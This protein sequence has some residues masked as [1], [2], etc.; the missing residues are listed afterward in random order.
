MAPKEYN[1]RVALF[2]MGGVGKT[3]IAIEYVVQFQSQYEGVYWIMA[4]SSAQLLSGF[5]SI[6]IETRCID[7]ASR[8]Q[9]EIAQCVLNWLYRTK[10]WLLVMDNL[11][12]ISIANGYLPRLKPGGGHVLITTRD[13]NSL[14]IP[15]EGM[16]IEVHEPHEA[17]ELILR[18]AQL[19]NEIGTRSAI[20]VEALEIVRSLGF[21]ALAIE[22]A[23]AYIREELARDIFM[24]RPIYLGQRRQLLDRQTAGNYYKNTVA[25]TWL[26]S[27]AVIEGRNPQANQL[28]RIFAFMNP[29]GISLEFLRPAYGI[30]SDI[31]QCEDLAIFNA[32]LAKA[33]RDL[34][35]FSLIFRRRPGLVQI[36]RLVQF[37]IKDR[38]STEELCKY[39][40]LICKLGLCVFPDFAPEMRMKCRQ[41]EGEIVTIISEIAETRTRDAASLMDRVGI[42]FLRDG[43]A[44]EAL[45]LFS[46]ATEIKKRVNGEE[47]PETVLSLDS[48]ASS[49]RLLGKVTEAAEMQEKVLE[50]KCRML[51]E[52]HP[53]TLLTMDNLANSYVSLG[54]VKEA[55]EMQE[56]V[57]EVK[58]RV[59][60]EEHP[61]TLSTM[62]NLANSYWLLGKAEEIAGMQ[63]EVLEAKCRVLGE[64]H[65]DTLL[66][67]DSL[68]ISYGSLGKVKEAAEMQEKV[69]EVKC[70]I[71]GEEHPDTLLTMHNLA[72]SYGL[73][74]KVTEA[75]EMQEKVLEVKCRILGEEHPD[76]LLTV[77]NLANSYG[78]RGNVKE[79]PEMQEKVLEVECRFFGE[80]HSD[81]GQPSQS[82]WV[83]WESRGGS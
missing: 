83:T 27:M 70:R 59:W 22:Q 73:L 54:K 64:E 32:H 60:G 26:L 36:H 37:V 29:D 69:L 42:Y 16:Q 30:L 14:S 20:E 57:L 65:P 11:D 7:T 53:D 81:H 50:A 3:Q 51:G 58:C 78:L 24:F 74:G 21:L 46:D 72:N 35:Q 45:R 33:L 4:E 28:L 15:T 10:D 76:T 34:E 12:D 25:T 75:T 2:G 61:D 71:L 8:T 67:M 5:V 55:A 18:R 77:H 1:H 52:E 66:T 63:E 40:F 38:M 17:T 43:K 62:H 47:H 44:R 79:A 48:L 19:F 49:Y 41:Y 39:R 68:A 80:E 6:A 82:I 13:P 56:K 23:A 9:T 31:L